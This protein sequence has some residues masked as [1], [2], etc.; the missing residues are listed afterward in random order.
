MTPDAGAVALG[1]LGVV[2]VAEAEV[3][4]LGVL[5]VVG[6]AEAEVVALGVL[7]VVGVAEAEVVAFEVLGGVV[8]LGFGFTALGVF[9]EAAGVFDAAGAGPLSLPPLASRSLFFFQSRPRSTPSVPS[10]AAPFPAL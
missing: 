1:V 6:V 9:A 8:P 7:G 5:G 4:A 3:V 10:W 2:G